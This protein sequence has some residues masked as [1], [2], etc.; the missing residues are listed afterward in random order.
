MSMP[1]S[2]PPP[3]SGVASQTLRPS[4]PLFPLQ[5]HL[6]NTGVTPNSV[7]GY[8]INVLPVWPDYTGKGRLIALMDDAMDESHPDLVAN[9]RADLGWDLG[10]NTPGAGWYPWEHAVGHG[11]SVA[12]LI[13]AAA[14]NGIGGAGVAWDAQF[15]VYRF[16][17][18]MVTEFEDYYRM[19]FTA[20]D[21]VLEQGVEVFNNSWGTTQPYPAS[22]DWQA[23]VHVAA[24][25]LAEQGRDSLGVVTIFSAGNERMV[26]LNTN[27]DPISS[28][29]WAI[30]V[31]AGS[32]TGDIAVYSTPGAGVLVTAPGSFPAS[33]VT[34]DWQSVYGSNKRPG[35]EGNYTDR[36]ETYFDGTSAAAPILSG[37]VALM[38]EANDGLGWRD[39]QEILAYSAR[40]A[41][42]LDREVIPGV[43]EKLIPD[44]VLDKNY[45]GARD[46]NGGAHLVSHDF[47]FGH[48]DAQAAVRLA[49]SWMALGTTANLVVAEGQVAQR[50]L[51]AGP[52]GQAIATASFAA[53]YR[54][55]HMMVTVDLETDVLPAITLELISPDG[56]VSRLIDHPQPLDRFREPAPL[57]TRVDYTMHSVQSWGEN[58]AGTWTL[59]LTND[60]DD[61]GDIVRLKD[62]SITAYTAGAVEPRAAQQIFTDE[63]VRFAGEDE[64]RRTLDAENGVT[65][66]AAAVTHN[67]VFDLS[68]L[69]GGL[70][71]SGV[72]PEWVE[73]TDGRSRIGDIE[74]TLNDAGALRNLISGDGDDLL[75]GNARE[76]ILMPGRGTNFVDGGAGLDVLRLIG[77][78]ADYS[79]DAFERVIS[80][81]SDARSGGEWNHISNVE[82]LSFAD[83]VVLTHAPSVEGP[84]AF[85]EAGYLA[86]YADVAAAVSAGA[87]ASGR[88][89]YQLWGSH[90]G[91]N[92]NTLF[93]EAWY[94]EHNSDVAEAVAQGLL[95]NGYVHYSAWGWQEGRA[96]SAWLNTAAYLEANPDVAAAGMDPLLHYLQYGFHEGRSIVALSSEMWA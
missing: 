76:N 41:T 60:A 11:T 5:W 72:N 54:V 32:Q 46:W 10:S 67:V 74:I 25:E 23:Q 69:P 63:F 38:L 70:P 30:A 14:N 66:N 78:S 84:D 47:G 43:V 6:H 8:D 18:A 24:R 29:P 34:T 83:R 94:L 13:A 77:R 96:P 28:M 52:G 12:G 42:F 40:R 80:V 31:A 93:S 27:Y 21:K 61:V 75:L 51:V 91:R 22:G 19:F 33:I 39:V 59:R 17:G 71:E 55:E 62:W 81:Y 26:G 4:D 68:G 9:Y 50:E 64:S 36:E 3:Q 37:V 92:P 35:E 82:L 48:V 56:T 86:Q 65:L 85:D 16:A 15:T 95:P 45:N 73:L 49:E 87:I 53:P 90:E 89:H 58:L 44:F 79:V 2:L 1:G 20:V 88:A 57:P 7:A